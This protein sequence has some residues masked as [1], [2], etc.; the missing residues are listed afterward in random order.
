MKLQVAFDVLPLEEALDLARGMEEDVDRFEL[1]TPFL[2]EHGMEAVR[3]FRAQFPGQRLAAF[4]VNGQAML[5]LLQGIQAAGIQIGSRF[6]VCGFDDWGWASLIPPGIT[7]ITQ[8]SWMVGRRAAE[9]LMERIAGE[10]PD[11]PIYEELPNRM[12]VRGSTTRG[13]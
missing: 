5:G 7:T 4:A 3:R 2:L 6:G 11:Y 13:D 10:G 12:E 9:L 1:G 8:D